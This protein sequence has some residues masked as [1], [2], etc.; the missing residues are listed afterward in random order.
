M[1]K[2]QLLLIVLGII[3][4][5]LA[6]NT[7]LRMFEELGERNAYDNMAQEAVAI[8][9]KAFAWRASPSAMAGG[10]SAQ[11]LNGVTAEALGFERYQSTTP[12]DFHDDD[13]YRWIRGEN[14]AR[15]YVQIAS[16]R[17]PELMVQSHVYGADEACMTF[18]TIR[19][20]EGF[21]VPDGPI[22]DAPAG[23]PGWR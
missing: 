15:P 16:K 12:L 9:T 3:A 22:P 2:Q 13:A 1:G 14:S 5:L 18:R 19:R 10:S 8:A 6:I 20:L 4:T 17:Y 23:C 11:Y 21:W 7:G